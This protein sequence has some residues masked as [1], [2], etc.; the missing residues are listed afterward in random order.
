MR[1]IG[2]IIDRISPHAGQHSTTSSNTE[3]AFKRVAKIFAKFTA[4][5]GNSFASNLKDERI[6]QLMMAEW[7]DKLS[8]YEDYQIE[9]GLN[10]LPK[11]F[12]PDL[13]TFQ[14]LCLTVPVEEKAM[15]QDH[16]KRLPKIVDREKNKKTA[17]S[18]LAKMKETLK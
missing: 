3:E 1:Q 13:P 8:G 18:S 6:S 9:R 17:A 12:A 15:Y 14:E 10:Q 5:Y 7:A 16:Q 4:N 2:K 11:G